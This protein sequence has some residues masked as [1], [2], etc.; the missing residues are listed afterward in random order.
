MS[1]DS[2]GTSQTY[3]HLYNHIFISSIYTRFTVE[4]WELRTHLSVALV[5]HIPKL[6]KRPLYMQ[7]ELPNPLEIGWNNSF[8]SRF[9]FSPWQQP[10]SS[11]LNYKG[12]FQPPPYSLSVITTKT[13]FTD[14]LCF[15]VLLGGL[16]T[17]F[18]ALASRYPITISLLCRARRSTS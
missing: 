5:C 13:S 8:P 12:P 2:M 10:V 4:N 14:H 6:F 17:A 9:L 1:T 16:M 3:L 11:S 15:T 7:V 18:S